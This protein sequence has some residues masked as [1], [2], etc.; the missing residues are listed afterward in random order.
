MQSPR[1]LVFCGVEFLVKCP[2]IDAVILNSL[3][4]LFILEVTESARAHSYYSSK[5][6]QKNQ[7]N[8]GWERFGGSRFDCKLFPP[9]PFRAI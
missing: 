7:L 2:S 5:D 3:A 6:V 8:S 1:G 9:P 4:L